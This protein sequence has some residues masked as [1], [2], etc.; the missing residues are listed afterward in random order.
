MLPAASAAATFLASCS[1]C[2]T[3]WSDHFT[4]VHSKKTLRALGR[5]LPFCFHLR[6]FLLPRYLRPVFPAPAA[7]DPA[8]PSSWI[9]L[10]ISKGSAPALSTWISR[11]RPARLQHFHAR[12][13]SQL[14]F[15]NTRTMTPESMNP[16]SPEPPVKVQVLAWGGP[17]ACAPFSE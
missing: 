13:S 6:L 14:E 5:G 3:P 16:L 2:S 8:G 9:R 11:F 4:P 17:P 12:T 10:R 15:I 1:I 7:L